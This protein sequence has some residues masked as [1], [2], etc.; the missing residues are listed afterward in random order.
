MEE[1]GQTKRQTQP[2]ANAIPP[3][4]NPAQK[5]EDP[6]ICPPVDPNSVIPNGQQKE[7]CHCRPDQTP[8]MKIV[9]EVMGL[10]ILTAYTIAAFRQLGIM[11]D[12]LTQ[13][14]TSSEQ[15]GSQTNDLITA[16]KDQVNAANRFAASADGINAQT[17]LAVSEFDRMARAAESN[18]A[19]SKNSLD[20]TIS[21]NQLDQRAWIGMSPDAPVV[22]LTKPVNGSFVVV[23]T[24]KTPA[25]H[26]I[27]R[28]WMDFFPSMLTGLPV[29][30]EPTVNSVGVIFPGGRGDSKIIPTI[31]APV[32]QI[33]PAINNAWFLYAWGHV[34]YSDVFGKQH[35]TQVCGY[36]KITE[37]GGFTQCNFGND[38]D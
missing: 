3:N 24:G 10:I 35:N 28:V 9:L 31:N 6:P 23:N 27:I 12:Q 32:S 25:K 5:N 29:G 20:A 1:S 30:V 14:K 18:A 11:R 7:P 8:V 17:K 16:A 36:R 13:M 34:E 21:Q 4:N 15:S 2:T 38:A 22:D 37:D 19:Q 33:N 26:V